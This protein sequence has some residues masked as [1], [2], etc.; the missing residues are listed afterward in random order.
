MPSKL[1][2]HDE[3]GHAHFWTISCYRRLQFFHDEGMK[4]VV[5]DAL[6][7]LQMRLGVC[8]LGYVMMPEHLHVLVYPQRRG[9]VAPIPIAT[10]LQALKQYVG[11]HG[12][13]RLREI[14][15]RK[16]RLWSEPLNRWA[17]GEFHKQQILYARGYDRN[18]FTQDEL[19]QKLDYCHKNPV[20]RGLVA[21]AA[22]WRWS[23]YR[24]FEYGDRSPLPMDWDGGWPVEW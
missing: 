4:R 8:L 6:R 18:V 17:R 14:W 9:D 16:G 21:D 11:E 7:T 13:S 22:H 2:R 1:H 15:R 10:V 5:I 23:S 24:F 19:Y 12:K 20:T 3:F